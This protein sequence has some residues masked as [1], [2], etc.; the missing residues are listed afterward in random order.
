MLLCLWCGRGPEVLLLLVPPRQAHV[1]AH[2]EDLDL[3][4]QSCFHVG[5]TKR[6][7]R[8]LALCHLLD[9]IIPSGVLKTDI[10][11]N[12]TSTAHFHLPPPLR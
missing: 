11:W 4:M 3:L 7:P 9:D 2:V 1:D 12:L 8:E 10:V 5:C 6:H